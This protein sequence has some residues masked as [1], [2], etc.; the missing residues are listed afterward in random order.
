MKTTARTWLVRAAIALAAVLWVA[1]WFLRRAHDDN[2][3]PWSLV[4][5]TVVVTLAAAGAVAVV[6]ARRSRALHDE[7]RRQRPHHR[8]A[9]GWSDASLGPTLARLGVPAR[10]RRLGGT[11]V[12]L[13][14]SPDGIEL[15][16]AGSALVTTVPWADIAD[17]VVGTGTAGAMPRDAVAIELHAGL[18]LVVVPAKNE[19]GGLVPASAPQTTALATELAAR[20][21]AAAGS[22]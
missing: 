9:S 18:P 11:P 6:L 16:R 7:V 22:R 1:R 21:R 2:P 4:V 20:L 5:P 8:I 17:V 10:F 3:A 14:W 13:A 12:V 19:A 15:W